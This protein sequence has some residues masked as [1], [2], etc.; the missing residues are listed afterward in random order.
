MHYTQIDCE[1]GVDIKA[2]KA[3]KTKNA[4]SKLEMKTISVAV[5][6]VVEIAK[7]IETKFNVI[8]KVWGVNTGNVNNLQIKLPNGKVK[9]Y[10]FKNSDEAYDFL[11]D[12]VE[13]ME[14]KA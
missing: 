10:E 8:V 4:E 9:G 3:K 12:F 6:D 11:S 7:E 13:K 5:K 2:T 14:A 1:T